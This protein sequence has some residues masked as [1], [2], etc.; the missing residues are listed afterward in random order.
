[1]VVDLLRPGITPYRAFAVTPDMD[2]YLKTHDI[3]INDFDFDVLISGHTGILATKD[4]IKQN[5][6]FVLDVMDNIK[7][8]MTLVDSDKVVEKCVELTTEQWTGKLN[9]LDE[10][11]TEHCQAMKDYVG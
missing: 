10:F 9:N 6:Q 8:A 4:H 2:Q 1:M 11:M 3:L 7:E 5:K